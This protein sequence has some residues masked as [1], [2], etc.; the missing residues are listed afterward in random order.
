MALWEAANVVESSGAVLFCV[1]IVLKL[2]AYVKE[3]VGK[4]QDTS[5]D[6]VKH[7]TCHK[8]QRCE[9]APPPCEQQQHLPWRTLNLFLLLFFSFFYC[10]HIALIPSSV[11]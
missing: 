1:L 2:K 5:Q 11:S 7:G 10:K 4:I 8:M 6:V 9:S 3:A